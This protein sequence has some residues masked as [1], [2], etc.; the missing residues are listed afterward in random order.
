MH[1]LLLVRHLAVIT[2]RFLLIEAKMYCGNAKN[3]VN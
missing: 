1:T 3:K 2:V